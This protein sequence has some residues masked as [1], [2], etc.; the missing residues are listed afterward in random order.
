MKLAEYLRKMLMTKNI[1]NVN[2]AETT[3]KVEKM[4]V[5]HH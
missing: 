1:K 4:S 5:T 2:S 3:E